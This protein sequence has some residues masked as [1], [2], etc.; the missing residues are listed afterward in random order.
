MTP[1]ATQARNPGKNKFGQSD[2]LHTTLRQVEQVNRNLDEVG[3]EYRECTMCKDDENATNQ[4][5]LF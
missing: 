3:S 2:I 5:N 1:E 4:A